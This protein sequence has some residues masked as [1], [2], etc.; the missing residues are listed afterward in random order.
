MELIVISG[1]LGSGKTSLLLRLAK[2]FVGQGR[3]VAIIE[4]EVGMIGVDGEELKAEGLDVREIYSGCV[5]C[6]LRHDLIHT[7]LDLERDVKPDVVFLEPSGV[8]GP[9]QI[10]HC[11]CGYS[12]EIDKQLF[13]VVADAQ[14][15][16]VI[17]DFSMP[18]IH[19]GLEVADMVVI[20]K[21]D[22]VSAQQLQE[23]GQRVRAVNP[24]VDLLCV[25]AKEETNVEQLIERITRRAPQSKTEAPAD[26]NTDWPDASIFAATFTVK[27][28]V[29]NAPELIKA[30]LQALSRQLKAADGILIGHLKAILK[31]E[32]TGYLVFSVTE[33]NGI[34]TEKGR[35][36]LDPV[37]QLSVTV[38]A[39]VYGI[40]EERFYN[41]CK[42][43][44]QT[45]EESLNDNNPLFQHSTHPWRL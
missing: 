10:K 30:M 39:I 21:S 24:T 43:S 15:L 23:L 44:F 42:Q 6:S 38:N 19:D 41:L 40:E 29:A 16:P 35:L 34:S 27:S 1:F 17:R 3:K 25:S 37:T 26:R 2:A 8:A 31:T 13:L 12:G 45:L 5:C 9:K 33:E 18:L 20:N 22:L 28:P 11:L 36:P 7:L 32:P 4:N 14:R